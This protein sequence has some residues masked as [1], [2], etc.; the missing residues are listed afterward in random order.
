MGQSEVFRDPRVVWSAFS[1]YLEE[2]LLQNANNPNGTTVANS[3]LYKEEDGII[4]K[5]PFFS[6]EFKHLTEQI[7]GVDFPNLDYSISR[8]INYRGGPDTFYSITIQ[9]VFSD[10]LSKDFF[11]DKII[12]IGP[13]SHPG[14]PLLTPYGSMN[15][16]EILAN[17]VDNLT[18]SR[19]IH[20]LDNYWYY[21]ILFFIMLLA[22]YLISH[23]PQA[24]AFTGLILLSTL[25]SALSVWVFDT[26]YFW[27]PIISPLVMILCIW[28]VLI[29]YQ[30]TTI[31][32][33]NWVLHREK[34]YL[35]ELEQ[36]KNN[37]ISL[38]SHDLKTPIAKIQAIVDRL[39]TNPKNNEIMGDLQALRLSGEELNKYIQ[40][41]LKLLRVE[42]RDFKIIKEVS[43]INEV[44]E[45]VL[46]QLRPLAAEK[47]IVLDTFL[48]P[49]F[50]VEF[51][52]T[53]IREVILNLIENAIK[54]TPTTGVVKIES[55]E[56]DNHIEVDITDN[57]EGIKP[58]DL[59]NI[60]GKFV[61]GSNQDL[62]SKGTGLGLY[63]VKYF[64]ELHG[65]QVKLESQYGVGTKVGF[66]LPIDSEESN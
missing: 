60:W 6:T 9:D 11:K 32:R 14:N 2:P 1:N 13:E 65:G 57:G 46:Q 48:E 18:E 33:K 44:I 55:R 49:M 42:S 37:F 31:E 17:I 35:E 39:T 4:R 47:Q 53:L 5:F 45:D 64:I 62:K 25:L 10:S 23:Y 21:V 63:L 27:F 24:I 56:V 34:K 8:T 43:D 54:Y 29:G 22:V 7:S 15:R 3:A 51:D 12:I 20:R 59:K 61:R 58:E 16:S 30:A 26:Y 38:I 50:S 36:L 28:V 19:W 52:A 41:I 66:N 40:S